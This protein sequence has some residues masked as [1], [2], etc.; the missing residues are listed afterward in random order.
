MSSA[1]LEAECQQGWFLPEVSGG[2]PSPYLPHL[3]GAASIP[4]L[5]IASLHPGFCGYIAFSSV[6]TSP[7]TSHLS[8]HL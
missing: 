3:L 5:I 4:W 8:V 1:G 6:V 7:S 2:K